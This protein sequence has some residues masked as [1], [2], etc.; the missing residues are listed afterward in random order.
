MAFDWTAVVKTEN[1]R[2]RLSR[3][4]VAELPRSGERDCQG[5]R[6]T[7]FDLATSYVPGMTSYRCGDCI[8]M[9]MCAG[10]EWVSLAFDNEPARASW[11][12][13]ADYDGK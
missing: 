12:L 8:A 6:G 5:E 10:Y 13:K 1:E 3:S 11:W 7:C 2:S 9:P 4:E